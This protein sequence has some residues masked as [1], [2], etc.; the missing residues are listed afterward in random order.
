V[1]LAEA[2]S[3]AYLGTEA[4]LSVAFRPFSDLAIE[5]SG[6]VFLP[7]AALFA[8]ADAWWRGVVTVSLSF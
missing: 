8:V 7:N 2:S 5:A 1:T 3:S 6:G 4:D